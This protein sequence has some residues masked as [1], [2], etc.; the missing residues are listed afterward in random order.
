LPRSLGLGVSPGQR[1]LRLM[2][3]P[4][5]W[6]TAVMFVE[7]NCRPKAMECQAG[8]TRNATVRHC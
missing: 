7:Q 6:P 8:L 4:S 1:I 5:L 2:T 3:S